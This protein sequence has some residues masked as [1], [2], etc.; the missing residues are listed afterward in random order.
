MNRE[1]LG[2]EDG[3]TVVMLHGWGASIDLLRPLGERLAPLGYRVVMFDLPG[4]GQ[5]PPPSTPWNVFDYAQHVAAEL[6]ALGIQKAH[7]FGHSFGGRLSLILG[8]DYPGRV[9]KLVL[10]D[11]AGIRAPLPLMIRARTGGYKG[12]RRGLEAVGLRGLS[13]RLRAAYNARYGS[14]DFNAASG[15]M[16]ET[17]VKVVNQD[18]R[19][20]AKRV[21][22]PTLLFWGSADEDTPLEQ[23]RELESLIPDAGLVVFEG[24]GHYAY[25]ERAADTA[26]IIHR[27]LSDEEK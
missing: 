27:F 16:R 5:T 4:F 3:P 18:L 6:D 19:D 26:R 17:F 20:W 11:A 1:V 12:L 15:V 21:A 10:S 7:V 23:G 13:E 9:G 2:P 14:S 25:L 24:A 8:A 22:A